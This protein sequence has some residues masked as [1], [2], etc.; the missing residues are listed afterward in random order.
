[1]K[2]EHSSILTSW[3]ANAAH[4]IAALEGEELET[5]KL[6]TNQAIVNTIIV[7]RPS[8]ILDVGC[9]EGWLCR[10]LQQHNISTTGVD[11]VAELIDHA[12][13]KSPGHFEV[14]SF[15]A[16]IA[17]PV[18]TNNLF[19]GVVLNFC[20][21][22]NEITNQLLQ[23]A[24][25][26]VKPNGKLFIQTLHPFSVLV[27]DEPYEDGWKTETWAGLKRS[28]THPYTWYYRTMATWIKTIQ[29]AGW[30]NIEIQEPVH[31]VK[32][33]PVSLIITATN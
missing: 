22:E 23:Q 9:G 17:S 20:L 12:R 24:T 2:V 28:F 25:N 1:M 33:K 26:W 21:Y 18:S 16:L 8:S 11:G 30:K 5:R 27:Q 29:E 32:M 31:P 3:N 6:I 10:A 15:E 13:S 7:H 4:W 14:K 19:D